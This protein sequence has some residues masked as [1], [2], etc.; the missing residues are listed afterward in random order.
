MD[1]SLHDQPIGP[2]DAAFIEHLAL[3]LNN[4]KGKL[5]SVEGY[6]PE[7]PLYDKTIS[8]SLHHNFNIR[9]GLIIYSIPLAKTYY[10]L[11]ADGGTII[12]CK[13][14]TQGSGGPIGVSDSSSL[15]PMTPVFFMTYP[16]TPEGYIIGTNMPPIYATN[17]ALNDTIVPDA[18]VGSVESDT[19]RQLLQI[20]YH[21]SDYSGKTP[22]DGLELGEFCKNTATGTMIFLDDFMA[23]L[24]AAED[25]GVWCFLQDGLLRTCGLNFEQWSGLSEL[26]SSIVKVPTFYFGVASDL[27]S[28]FGLS[29][30]P[31]ITSGTF[32]NRSK[33]GRKKPNH[34]DFE[35]RSG[36]ASGHQQFMVLPYGDSKYE[37]EA[38][39]I[40]L[41]QI[42]RSYT[43]EFGVRSA[44]G[45]YLVKAPNVKVP[46]RYRT[47][48]EGNER[49]QD[50]RRLTNAPSSGLDQANLINVGNILDLHVNLFF[51]HALRYFHDLKEHYKLIGSGSNASLLTSIGVLSGSSKLATSPPSAEYTA[52]ELWPYQ[53]ATVYPN[54]AH[55]S[56]TPDGSI[57]L[58]D[59]Y[60]SEIQLTGGVIKITAAGDVFLDSGRNTLIFAGRDTIC[61][62]KKHIEFSSTEADV[63]IKAENNIQITAGNNGK[64][65]ILL[66]SRADTQ[67]VGD[68]EGKN[69]E[70][71]QHPGI[72]L[73]AANS[74][75]QVKT[76]RLINHACKQIVNR[77]P[78]GSIVS[79]APYIID[80]VS[81]ALVQTFDPREKELSYCEM[82]GTQATD[83]GST[84]SPGEGDQQNGNQKAQPPGP[85]HNIFTHDLALF[86][87]NLVV[88]NDAMITGSLGVGE[89]GYVAGD[90]LFRSNK[91]QELANIVKAAAG[92]D[93]INKT[94]E[95][96]G[97][98]D[99]WSFFIMQNMFASFR[100]DPEQ[101]SDGFIYVMPRWAKA[102]GIKKNAWPERPLQN[103]TFDYS[104]GKGVTKKDTIATFP[105]PG[106]KYY[107][108][109][110][111]N[112]TPC[113]LITYNAYADNNG[114]VIV[115]IPEMGEPFSDDQ[116][117]LIELT[118]RPVIS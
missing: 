118:S 92:M 104:I 108:T 81:C 32:D 58:G 95:F 45:I 1:D 49:L 115:E 96:I 2:P 106:K 36:I 5:S 13:L 37:Q 41:S 8:H 40:P 22:V 85:V 98:A 19:Y 39:H 59:G 77:V 57:I 114:N 87:G 51:G 61:R 105:F 113:I 15:P 55:F 74:A 67:N 47:I 6:R 21:F 103:T 116:V 93:I 73:I 46:D 82:E 53:K 72:N 62:T 17:Q 33:Y 14:I 70:K 79:S 75:V 94:Y 50:N 97:D 88:H 91:A 27:F 89:H 26:S 38:N 90:V 24:R 80:V 20:A 117:E 52:N 7:N 3:Q 29:R 48:I 101:K 16:H 10:V 78:D 71:T 84:P 60:G 112:F 63:R 68:W 64:G 43:G 31:F 83:T 86:H 109:K 69:G 99:H 44:T 12:R 54:T 28:N 9:V 25:C 100:L 4:L 102:F 76:Q 42:F 111:K 18:K 110:D 35:Y 23:V 34:A 66:E 56:I 65:G 107:D 11:P 30:K